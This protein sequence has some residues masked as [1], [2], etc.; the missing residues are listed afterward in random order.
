MGKSAASK[1]LV[2]I[3][4]G[5][6]YAAST[7]GAGAGEDAAYLDITIAGISDYTK[8]EVCFIGAGG[9]IT[10]GEQWAFGRFITT[11]SQTKQVTGRLLNNTTLRVALPHGSSVVTGYIGVRYIIKEYN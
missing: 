5:F 3:L 10:T 9:A 2:Q 6:A 8:C 1:Q 7:A 4:Q 11:S